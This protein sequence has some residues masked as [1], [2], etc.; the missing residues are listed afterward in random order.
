MANEK[1]DTNIQYE[2]E[3][4]LPQVKKKEQEVSKLIEQEKGN[5]EKIIEAAKSKAS[6]IIENSR[7]DLPGLREK[8]REDS[9][10]QAK[11]DAEKIRGD[12]DKSLIEIKEKASPNIQKAAKI[13][14][15]E[16]IPH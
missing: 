12:G 1:I 9:I 8:R 7:K 4:A 13:V 14:L 16:I 2:D 11:I 15:S 5:A 6:S 10:T 3:S